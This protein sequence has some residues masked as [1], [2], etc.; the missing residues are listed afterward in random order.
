MGSNIDRQ[1]DTS[2]IRPRTGEE[3]R[4]EARLYRWQLTQRLLADVDALQPDRRAILD[5]RLPGWNFPLTTE[6]LDHAVSVV[7]AELNEALTL[8]FNAKGLHPTPLTFE[9][10]VGLAEAEG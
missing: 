6:D 1:N 9:D 3:R 10:I 8:W 7:D 5:A 4:E 2:N